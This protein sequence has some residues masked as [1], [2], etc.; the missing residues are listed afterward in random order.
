MANRSRFGVKG[1]F[2]KSRMY[3]LTDRLDFLVK[4][5]RLVHNVLRMESF[6]YNRQLPLCEDADCARRHKA[7]S[8]V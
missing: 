2:S 7:Y 1:N 3:F 4:L 5:L 6:G 8:N